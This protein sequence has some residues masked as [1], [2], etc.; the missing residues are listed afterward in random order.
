MPDA[1][2]QQDRRQAF[3]IQLFRLGN[4]WRR[5]LNEKLYAL[6]LTDATWRPLFHLGRLGDGL[7]QKDLADAMFI[8]GPSLVRLLD[9]LERDALILRVDDPTDRRCKL[10]RLTDAGRAIYEQAAEVNRRMA[11]ELLE[12]LSDD[13]AALCFTIFE[14]LSQRMDDFG[15]DGKAP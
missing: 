11:D 12:D 13:E 1:T 2:Q 3:G 9:N 15:R 8:E 10:I 7:R 5:L 14:R 6:G 4:R